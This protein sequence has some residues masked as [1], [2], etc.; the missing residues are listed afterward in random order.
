MSPPPLQGIRQSLGP[1]LRAGFCPSWHS[2]REKLSAHATITTIINNFSRN[3]LRAL[4]VVG[5]AP[6]G[7]RVVPG[8][9]LLLS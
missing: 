9:H 6:R 4:H 1:A 3:L 8:P 5:L 7:G 2:C